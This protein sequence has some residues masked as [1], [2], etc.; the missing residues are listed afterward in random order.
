MS[1]STST[2]LPPGLRD[3]GRRN[4]TNPLIKDRITIEKYGHETNGEYTLITASV[5]PGGGTPLHYHNTYEEHLTPV[6]GTL[7]IVLGTETKMF[8]E[9]ET[10]VVPKGT[11]HRFFN[12]SE[13][14][15]VFS[16]K[17][18]PAHEG[19]EKSIYIFYGMAEDAEAREKGLIDNKGLPTSVVTLCLLGDMGEMPLIKTLAAYAR[20][21]GE[22][23]RL[24]KKY[25]H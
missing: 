3:P 6:K 8:K 2:Q 24:L 13:E 23:E 16:G 17:V 14:E 4:L 9:G 10:A 11:L 7:G 18:I 15:V 22:E 21:S 5:L 12:D 20:W 25:W 1:T 19:F